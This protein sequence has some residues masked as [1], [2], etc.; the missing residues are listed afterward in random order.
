MRLDPFAANPDPLVERVALADPLGDDAIAGPVLDLVLAELARSII[1]EPDGAQADV[2]RSSG[3]R[4]PGGRRR[5]LSSRVSRPG[6]VV[7]IAVSVVSLSATAAVAYNATAHTGFFGH[8]GQTENDTSEFLN[9]SAPDF[10]AILR[11]LVPTEIALPPDASWEPAI[12]RQIA[13]G[14]GDRGLQQA[15]GLRGTLALYAY[16]SW[17]GHWL[18]VQAA[19]DRAA[20]ADAVAGIA[21][22]PESPV[23]AKIDGGGVRE[24]MR[25][26]ATAAGRGQVA[27]VQSE[28]QLNCDGER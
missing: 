11:T 5:R 10:P 2:A 24:G 20:A 4:V 27:P 1:A 3:R 15:T 12:Q 21:R 18:D 13:F 26:I 17:V 9:T 22:I 6:R 19:G 14:Q 16:C 7:L 25:R 28:Y 8:P 23:V